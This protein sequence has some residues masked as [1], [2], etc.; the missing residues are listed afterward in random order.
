[1][2]CVRKPTTR[3]LE[4]IRAVHRETPLSYEEVGCSRSVPPPGYVVDNNRVQLGTGAETFERAKQALKSWQMLQLGWV[5]PCWPDVTVR[6]G[7]LV[8]TLA[9]ACGLWVVNVCRIVYLSETESDSCHELSF[10]YGTLEGHVEQG[11]E[12]FRVEWNRADDSVWYEILAFSK[13]GRWIAKV[14]YP[15]VRSKQRQFARDSL[16]VMRNCVS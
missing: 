13:P 4:E 12:R 11:E 8:G 9:R 16:Q 14:G 7:E 6:E 10:A 2:F 15:Y 3:L 1:M 5:E